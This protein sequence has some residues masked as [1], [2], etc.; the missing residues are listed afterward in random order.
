MPSSKRNPSRVTALAVSFVCFL[1]A[2]CPNM[3][4]G[5]SILTHEAIIDAA[6]DIKIRP[7]L[8][9]R[10]PNATPEQLKT[11]HAYAYGGAIIQDLGYYPHGS[12]FFSDLNSLLPNRR[13]HSGA[14]ARFARPEWLCIRDRGSFALCGR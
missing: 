14:A 10:F 5:Y 11:A 3:A 4:Q 9:E 12:H 1:S 2:I 8:L 6:W 13:F 7:L